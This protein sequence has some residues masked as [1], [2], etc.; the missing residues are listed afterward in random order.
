MITN[1]TFVFEL[2]QIVIGTDFFELTKAVMRINSCGVICR[3]LQISSFSCDIVIDV[4]SFLSARHT[5][6]NFGCV[7]DDSC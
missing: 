1:M 3:R 6:P 7:L 2:I 5:F 4:G